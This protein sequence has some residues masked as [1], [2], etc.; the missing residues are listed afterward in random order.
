MRGIDISELCVGGLPAKAERPP[1]DVVGMAIVGRVEAV[2][3][4]EA[5]EP[6]VMEPP[7]AVAEVGEEVG[8]NGR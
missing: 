6:R 4:V 3:R 7:L 1:V 2:I 5:C 8:S